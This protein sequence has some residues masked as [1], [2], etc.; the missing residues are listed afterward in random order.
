MLLEAQGDAVAA[1]PYFEQALAIFEQILGP[2]H[3]YTE[4]VRENLAKLGEVDKG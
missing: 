4:T 3:P 1:R 2:E